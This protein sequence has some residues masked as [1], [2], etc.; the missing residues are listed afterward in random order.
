[1]KATRIIR[2]GA[3]GMSRNRVR[4]SFMVLATFAGVAALTV[5]AAIGQSTQRDMLDRLDRMLG[6]SSI[7]LR[8][9][10]GQ[11]RGGPQ[12]MGG[13]TTTLTLADMQALD[14][15]VPAVEHVDPI[16]TASLDVVYEGT[17][18][19]IRVEGHGDAA[20]IVWDRSVTRGTFISADDVAGAARVALLGEVVVRDLFGGRDPVG[21][22][23]RIANVPFQVIGVLEPI[24]ADPHGMD[25]DNEIVIPVTT[26]MRRVLNVDYIVNAKLGL[27]KD[28]DVQVVADEV[29]NVLRERHALGPGVPD[30]FGIFTPI[31]VQGFVRSANRTFTVFLP[32]VAG[33]SILVACLVVANLMLMNVHERRAE[34]GLR[35]AVGARAR[36]IRLQFLVES[37]AVT[38]LGGVI[39][40]ALAYGGLKLVAMHGILPPR[41]PWQPALLGLAVAVGVGVVAGVAPARRAAGLDPVTTLR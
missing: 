1:M 15:G 36:D 32:L 22:Q 3:R 40:V 12:G 7:L 8:A 25:K 28:A 27:R 30:D 17:S 9:G 18:T 37:A 2:S 34:I 26:L 23:I 4:T 14:E 19:R 6:G 35:R 31:Q 24:G 33:I 29:R 10:G 5:T 41:M 21:A 39:A 20:E 16:M 11:H 13:P 38:A